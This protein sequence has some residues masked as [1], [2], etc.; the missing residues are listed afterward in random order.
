MFTRNCSLKSRSGYM[1]IRPII[2]AVPRRD[3]KR[4]IPPS[5]SVPPIAEEVATGLLRMSPAL[6]RTCFRIPETGLNGCKKAARNCNSLPIP[7]LDSGEQGLFDCA[8]LLRAAAGK[9]VY[10]FLNG[11]CVVEQ[12]LR[13]EEE[14][15]LA[16]R[17]I[18]AV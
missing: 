8:N 10:P 7:V 2:G 4:R 17:S 15:K 5:E 1:A 18:G 12:F 13:P 11:L 16:L 14:V 3:I 6:A 9:I